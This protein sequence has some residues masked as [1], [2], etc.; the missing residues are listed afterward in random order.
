MCTCICGSSSWKEWS[1]WLCE[2]GPATAGWLPF[3]WPPQGKG[4][5]PEWKA[6]LL[7]PVRDTWPAF[8]RNLFWL[9]G[10]WELLQTKPKPNPENPTNRSSALSLN[11]D[12][13]LP[14]ISPRFQFSLKTFQSS[15][16]ML[17]LYRRW[18]Y[19]RTSIFRKCFLE[20]SMLI[21]YQ[22]FLGSL[23]KQMTYIWFLVSGSAYGGPQIKT[24]FL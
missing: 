7:S 23:P 13:L 17:Y 6:G 2:G 16:V 22:C 24:I 11:P 5:L 9:S 21:P 8:L 15:L 10:C 3:W 18:L 12:N 20:K 14:N 1:E 19:R 4:W